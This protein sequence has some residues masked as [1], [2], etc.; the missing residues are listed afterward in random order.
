MDQDTDGIRLNSIEGV[1]LGQA[2]GERIGIDGN[3]SFPVGIADNLDVKLCSCMIGI[4]ADDFDS[5]QVDKIINHHNEG[6]QA[7]VRGALG[8]TSLAIPAIG[9]ASAILTIHK[10]VFI[11]TGTVFVEAEEGLDSGIRD[12]LVG[13]ALQDR[14]GGCSRSGALGLSGADDGNQADYQRQSQEDTE[15][16]GELL[17]VK[18]SLRFSRVSLW[19]EFGLHSKK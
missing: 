2:V 11:I 12:S 14:T 7:I 8:V 18:T 5:T 15:K 10:G 13:C 6:D 16:L 1:G 17:H 19:K 4:L 9:Y 3:N